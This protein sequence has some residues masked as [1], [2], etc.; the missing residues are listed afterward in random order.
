MT[1]NDDDDADA[2]GDGDADGDECRIS[3]R[4]GID[5]YLVLAGDCHS[6]E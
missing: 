1:M 5:K 3:L 2:G 6:S 4:Y